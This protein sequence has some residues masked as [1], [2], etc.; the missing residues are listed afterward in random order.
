MPSPFYSLGELSLKSRSR[1]F[2]GQ[3]N[4]EMTL[5]SILN[6]QNILLLFLPTAD[7]ETFRSGT[8]GLGLFGFLGAPGVW[9]QK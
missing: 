9:F 7:M 1:F 5:R 3:R 2:F 6:I 8:I 4:I